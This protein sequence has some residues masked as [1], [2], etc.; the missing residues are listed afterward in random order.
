M[1]EIRS[2]NDTVY[3][4]MKSAGKF[5]LLSGAQEIELGRQVQAMMKVL[6]L[7]ETERPEDWGL[8]VSQGQKAKT[9]MIKSNLRLVINVAKK[10][11]NMPKSI[12]IWAF[13]SRI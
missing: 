2:E 7:L 5:P 6:A 1:T 13:R 9:R 3:F 8:I 4:L 12:K 10:Y 11:Q